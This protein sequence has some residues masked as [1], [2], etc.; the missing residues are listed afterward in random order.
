LAAGEGFKVS[1][2]V[3]QALGAFGASLGLVSAL[4]VLQLFTFVRDSQ[5]ELPTLKGHQHAAKLVPVDFPTIDNEKWH[6]A[7][8]GIVPLKPST[9]DSFVRDLHSV[10]AVREM[11]CG[12]GSAHLFDQ[13]PEQNQQVSLRIADDLEAVARRVSI[14]KLEGVERNPGLE[15]VGAK[16]KLVDFSG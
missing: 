11:L 10:L 14:A 6:A 5:F 8:A 2:A 16:L 9:H 7:I 1:M 13:S 4:R 15:Q 12:Q 3:S